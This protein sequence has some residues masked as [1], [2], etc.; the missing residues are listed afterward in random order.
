LIIF[1][2]WKSAFKGGVRGAAADVNGDGRSDIVVGAGPGGVPVVR[3][4]DGLSL[5]QIDQFFAA[6]LNFRG[7]V[8]VA[9][10]GKWGIFNPAA[11]RGAEFARTASGSALAS[12]HTE[13]VDAALASL[14]GSASAEGAADLLDL[15]ES[16]P[17]H[18]R[19]RHIL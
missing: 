11:H 14:S 9:G 6:P 3:G 15:L 1:G 18:R 2:P 12:V 7:G 19:I 17:L 8:F 5:E 4:F 13:A 10:G 16:I